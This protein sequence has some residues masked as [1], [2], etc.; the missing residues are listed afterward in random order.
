MERHH[1]SQREEM[2]RDSERDENDVDDETVIESDGNT[3]PRDIFDDAEDGSDQSSVDED[4]DESDDDEKPQPGRDRIVDNVYATLNTRREAVIDYLIGQGKD[5]DEAK[6]E[7]YENMLPSYQKEFR[8][9]LGKT[10][11]LM[12][13]FRHEPLY[14]IVMDRAKQLRLDGLGRIESIHAAIRDRK[15]KIN[16]FMPDKYESEDEENDDDDEEEAPSKRL[17]ISM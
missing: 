2:D 1:R 10:I 11:E 9:Q 15:Y 8:K 12:D 16:K 3:R 14:K 7:A 5:E 13:Q 17:K 6:E 4:E